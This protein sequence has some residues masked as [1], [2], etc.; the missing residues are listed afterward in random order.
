MTGRDGIMTCAAICRLAVTAGRPS[1]AWFT[2]ARH[3]LAYL[4]FKLDEDVSITYTKRKPGQPIHPILEILT[5]SSYNSTS[6][7]RSMGGYVVC[8]A[9]QIIDYKSALSKIICLST[10]EAEL[11][12]MSSGAKT[13]LYYLQLLSEMGL[14]VTP[15]L[16]C[17]DNRSAWQVVHGANLTRSRHISYRALHIRDLV[18]DKLFDAKHVPTHLLVADALSKCMNNVT[19]FRFL[20]SC[21]MRSKHPKLIIRRRVV[22]LSK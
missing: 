21:M 22:E 3:V 9:G 5:D 18:A 14:V 6:N 12:A 10:C 17:N 1:E 16:L 7:S 15:V 13:G 20:R 2:A 4:H 11:Y 8:L 19:G